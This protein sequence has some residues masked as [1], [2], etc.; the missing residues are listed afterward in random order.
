[1][2]M[3]NLAIYAIFFYR[4]PLCIEHYH[5]A[6]IDTYVMA[7]AQL[8]RTVQVEDYVSLPASRLGL[9]LFSAVP[10]LF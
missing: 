2:H 1:M 9:L 6:R 7:Y 10:L 8:V 5:S 3:H 4:N